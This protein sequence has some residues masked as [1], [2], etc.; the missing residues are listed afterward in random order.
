MARYECVPT[1]AP[2]NTFVNTFKSRYS[3]PEVEEFDGVQYRYLRDGTTSKNNPVKLYKQY[4]I[5]NNF[6]VYRL[7]VNG[8][9]NLD[10]DEC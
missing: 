4:V 2:F 1:T 10:M 3:Y 7:G 6:S 9:P 8:S 5:G